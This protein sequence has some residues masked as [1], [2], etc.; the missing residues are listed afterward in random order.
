MTVVAL[1]LMTSLHIAQCYFC[2][3]LRSK[4]IKKHS[5]YSLKRELL[6]KTFLV[7]AEIIFTIT[8]KNN[9]AAFRRSLEVPWLDKEIRVSYPLPV[10]LTRISKV[11][12]LPNQ[13]MSLLMPLSVTNANQC[14]AYVGLLN[15]RIAS[16][17]FSP[18]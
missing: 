5:V 8:R 16:G 9:L 3:N 6:Q 10:Q 15:H 18:S 14:T 11:Y 4:L 7:I 2:N 1:S 13:T 12:A 17:I